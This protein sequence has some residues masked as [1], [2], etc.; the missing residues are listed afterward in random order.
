MPPKGKG[1]GGKSSKGGWRSDGGSKATTIKEFLASS[2]VEASSTTSVAGSD[3]GGDVGALQTLANA[4]ANTTAN[5]LY[6]RTPGSSRTIK[7][8][9]AEDERRMVAAYTLLREK[10][11]MDEKRRIEVMVEERLKE[12]LGSPTKEA[13]PK[14][15]ARKKK[16]AKVE[17]VELSSKE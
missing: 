1:K 5:S 13:T 8:E 17:I 2:G 10:E 7:L 15:S 12:T 3:A 14:K 6:A 11:A 16:K 9:S 4:L